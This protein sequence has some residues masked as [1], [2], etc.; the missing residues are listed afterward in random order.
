MRGTSKSS[1]TLGQKGHYETNLGAVLRQVATG[2]GGEYFTG[3]TISHEHNYLIAGPD[4]VL[5]RRGH[6]AMHA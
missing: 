1:V 4:G 2:G 5:W 3:A 6:G